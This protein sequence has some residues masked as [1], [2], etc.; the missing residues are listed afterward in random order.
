[1]ATAPAS[2]P[3]IEVRRLSKRFGRVLAV[4]DMSFSVGAG[5]VTG[6]LGPNGSG[7]TT[8][9]RALLGLVE[10][11]AGAAF[12]NGVAYRDL[13]DPVRTVGAVLESSGFH[14][15][16]SARSHLRVQCSAAGIDR[17][18]ADEVLELVGLGADADRSVGG[19]SMGMR[20]RLELARAVLGD[21]QV[22]VLD[23]PANGL[24]P[25]GIAWL[26]WFLRWY[27]ARGRVVLVSSHLLAE[28]AQTVDD[29]VIVSGGRLAAQGRL[30]DL[31]RTGPTA[32]EVTTHDAPRLA[33][34]LRGAGFDVRER[35]PDVVAVFGASPEQV[36][37]LMAEHRIV[38]LA[39]SSVSATGAGTLEQ[40]F[41]QLTG[42]SG[43]G[44]AAGPWQGQGPW[45]GPWQGQGAPQGQ[46]LG[47]GQGP[48]FGPPHGPDAPGGQHPGGQR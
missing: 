28:A 35:P 26:R 22:L 46:G 4:D 25:Q 8:T 13:S 21:P 2:V 16:R 36:G 18:R 32:I 40:L 30:S 23:E 34:A 19:Y 37:L 43:G 12:V 6:F 7:K 38:V 44:A 27:A 9:L 33:A 5:T 3:S 29:V 10:P 31:M 17:R 15:A 42:G 41:F 45:Q 48:G 47:Q 24:D 11:T 39:M 20:Q 1:M 14:P